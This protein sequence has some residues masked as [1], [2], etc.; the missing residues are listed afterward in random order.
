MTFTPGQRCISY[1]VRFR[2]SI[3]SPD[4]FK[5]PSYR[6]SYRSSLRQF[7]RPGTSWWTEGIDCIHSRNL[8]LK[9]LAI[10]DDY[11]KASLYYAELS[12]LNGFV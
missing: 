11:Q 1:E 10:I 8:Y 2:S 3:N 12:R 6:C 7:R 9:K 5:S 4:K